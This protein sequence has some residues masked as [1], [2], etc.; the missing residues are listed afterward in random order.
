MST[1]MENEKERQDA[2]P[3]TRSEYHET[4]NRFLCDFKIEDCLSHIQGDS[5]LDLA[6]G[7]GLMT[8]EFARSFSKVVGVDA[9]GDHLAK[10]RSRCPHIRFVE[11]LIETCELDETFDA[12]LMLDVLEHLIDPVAALKKAASFLKSGGRIVAHVPNSQA[13]NRQINV[14]MGSLT[15]CE[16][17]SPFDIEIAGHRRSYS[18]AS[19]RKDFESAGLRVVA[20]GGIFFKMLSTPQ[21]EWLLAQGE[22]DGG[23][24]GWGRSDQPDRDW[25]TEF[26]RACYEFGKQRPDDCNVIYAVGEIV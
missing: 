1:D 25:R 17:L 5:L 18:L 7:D 15:H 12:V 13:V 10:A 20:E 2:F 14:I 8:E 11:S 23:G 9:S 3:W 21:M 22:W 6:C 4:Y 19:L 16:E 24:H 26:C